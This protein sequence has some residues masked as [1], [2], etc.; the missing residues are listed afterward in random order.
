MQRS[1]LKRRFFAA[2]S[3]LVLISG[4]F[5]GLA[6]PPETI[7]EPILVT[8]RKMRTTKIEYTVRGPYL[9]G[10]IPHPSAGSPAADRIL[11]K[12]LQQCL[13]EGHSGEIRAKACLDDRIRR[14]AEQD[15]A[16]EAAEASFDAEIGEA[17]AAAQGDAPRPP[18]NPREITVTGSRYTIPPG[19]WRFVEYSTYST[20]RNRVWPPSAH[21]W[22]ACM[23]DDDLHVFANALQTPDTFLTDTLPPGC[24]S[25]KIRIKG[26]VISG[27]MTCFL[28]GGAIKQ[29]KLTGRI[30]A[31]RVEITKEE[32]FVMKTPKA[33]FFAVTQSELS[34]QRVG[35]C[36]RR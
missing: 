29:G 18:E 7:G 20:S 8:A 6:D 5:A 2:S 33:P 12:M 26:K 1:T 14:F 34:A 27:S 10:C 28:Q 19:L 25:W 4:S 3:G 23:T 16:I 22:Q 9:R 21:Q 36:S 11:C 15:V 31:D 24:R 32:R 17:L 35:E 30:D 13:L